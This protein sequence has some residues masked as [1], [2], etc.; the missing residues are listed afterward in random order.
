M[1][2]DRIR[3]WVDG[4]CAS[5]TIYGDF[6]DCLDTTGPE[7]AAAMVPVPLV[8]FFLEWLPTKRPGDDEVT[9]SLQSSTGP[10]PYLLTPVKQPDPDLVMAFRH[11]LEQ[12]VLS[13]E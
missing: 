2:E 12:R 7:K 1:I 9:F 5:G 8:S 3:A 10:E 13:M 6:L 4:R 11:C